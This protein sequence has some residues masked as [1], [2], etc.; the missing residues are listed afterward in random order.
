MRPPRMNGFI[1]IDAL[2]YSPMLRSFLEKNIIDIN[3]IQ[4]KKGQVYSP[5]EQLIYILP[6]ESIF[7][8]T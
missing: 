4:F 6:R 7:D 8:L 1:V 5:L 3:N 2:L